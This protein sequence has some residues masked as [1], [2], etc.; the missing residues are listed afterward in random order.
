MSPEPNRELLRDGA[1][2]LI[3]YA[4]ELGEAFR[5]LVPRWLVNASYVT[6]SGYV[7]ADTAWRAH[8]VPA[9][10]SPLIEAADTLL[11][12]ALAPQA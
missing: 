4:N 1:V 2:R 9:G 11:W 8:T 5:P 12:Q 7:L 6:A 3:G 10:R